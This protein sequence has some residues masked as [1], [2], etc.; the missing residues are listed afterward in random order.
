M[1]SGELQMC[2]FYL[3]IEEFYRGGTATNGTTVSDLSL[4]VDNK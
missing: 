3:V 2:V 4:I 1:Q